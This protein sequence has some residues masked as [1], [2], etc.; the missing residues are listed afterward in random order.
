MGK[1]NSKERVKRKEKLPENHE[2]KAIRQKTPYQERR[3]RKKGTI[4]QASKRPCRDSNRQKRGGGRRLNQHS[5]PARERSTLHGRDRG[6]SVLHRE[7]FSKNIQAPDLLKTG[8]N[9]GLEKKKKGT[10]L[11]ASQRSLLNRLTRLSRGLSMNCPCLQK[12]VP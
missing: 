2:K 8:R 9:Q 10:E 11:D 1:A 5:E 3:T 12:W 7:A 6:L 4:P